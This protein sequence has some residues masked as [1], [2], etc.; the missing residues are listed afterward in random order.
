MRLN[1]KKT[2]FMVLC[3]S[4]TIAPGNGDLTLSGAELEELRRLRVLGVT[5]NSKLTFETHL[6]EVVS[7]AARRLIIVRRAAKLLNCPRVLK[8]CF[9]EYVLSSWSIVPP[10]ESRLRSLFGFNG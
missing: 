7:K 9:N 6:R 5:L 8:S 2:E 1:P 3:R 4:R 10:C